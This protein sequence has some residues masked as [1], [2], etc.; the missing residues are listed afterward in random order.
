MKSAAGGRFGNEH[1][2]Q[3]WILLLP[4]DGSLES[5]HLQSPHLRNGYNNTG[6]DPGQYGQWVSCVPVV[7]HVLLRN[8]KLLGQF[9]LCGFSVEASTISFGSSGKC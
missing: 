2:T 4:L 1:D 7:W 5:N 3:R 9:L 8:N 6:M